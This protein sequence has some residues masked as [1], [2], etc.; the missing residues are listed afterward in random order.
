M[1]ADLAPFNP[2]LGPQPANASTGIYYPATCTLELREKV[3]SLHDDFTIKTV[4]GTEV[5]K[6]RGKVFSLHQK[7]KFTDMAG[8]ELFALQDKLVAVF[9]SFHGESPNGHDF[10]IKGKVRF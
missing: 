2:P 3:F 6:C 1:A 4:D 7:K 8:N 10:H 9:K 5:C